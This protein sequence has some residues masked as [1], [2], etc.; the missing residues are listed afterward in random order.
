MMTRKDYRAFAEAIN[1]VYRA[2]PRSRLVVAEITHGLEEVLRAD[3]PRFDRER[4]RAACFDE[5]PPS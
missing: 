5:R 1:R 4:F 3:N 2:S